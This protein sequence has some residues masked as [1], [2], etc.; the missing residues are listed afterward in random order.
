MQRNAFAAGFSLGRMRNEGVEYW[1]RV[2]KN[3]KTDGGAQAQKEQIKLNADEAEVDTMNFSRQYYLSYCRLRAVLKG[4]AP[5]IVRR[6]P[7]SVLLRARLLAARRAHIAGGLTGIPKVALA[8]LA[9]EFKETTQRV[10]VAWNNARP[11]PPA[12]AEPAEGQEEEEEVEEAPPRATTRRVIFRR[13]AR[14]GPQLAAPAALQKLTKDQL[15]DV[16][17]GLGL[18]PG[19]RLKHVLIEDLEMHR[20]VRAAATGEGTEHC[21]PGL[22]Q[23]AQT[24]RAKRPG[25]VMYHAAKKERHSKTAEAKRSAVSL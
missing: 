25:A 6:K 17:R 22:L 2:Q 10:L 23:F 24:T 3:V 5:V 1:H 15:A 20:A 14:A 9:V 12:R 19:T 21:N 11:P 8:E 13:V 7:V 18:D 16:C 4:I